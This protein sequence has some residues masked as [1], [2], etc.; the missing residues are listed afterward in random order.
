MHAWSTSTIS[1]E[2]EDF[3]NFLSHEFALGVSD[4]L[5]GTTRRAYLSDK[6]VCEKM[7]ISKKYK[8]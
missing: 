6:L 1:Q 3:G 5:D 8:G 7:R 4:L 2:E